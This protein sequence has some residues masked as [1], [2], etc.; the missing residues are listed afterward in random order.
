MKKNF[1][2][3]FSLKNKSF[4]NLYLF[5]NLYIRNLKYYLKK[6]YS[7]F[8]EDVFL[9]KYFNKKKGFYIDIGCHHPF[10]NNNTFLLYKAGWS[11][12]NIDLNQI[13]ID[14]FNIAR[15][16]DINICTAITN[17]NGLITYYL[18]DNNPL[19]SEITIS[20]NFSKILKNHHGNKYRSF[21]TKGKTWGSIEKKYKK[22][23]KSL[24]FLKIDVEGSDL[25]VL[26]S[27][28]LDKLN[29]RLVMV[30]AAHFNKMGRIKIITYLKKKNYKILYDNKL[31]I[32]FKKK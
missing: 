12:I 24:D 31:N 19:S 22:Y 8:D 6:S 16:R 27:I 32:I 4:Y 10:K 3:H 29:P 30:E 13:S 5:Y 9:N 25:K 26:K 23:I 14:L 11:G 21:T 1:F 18:P 7:Q 28:K 20:K 17:K 15:P 2:L